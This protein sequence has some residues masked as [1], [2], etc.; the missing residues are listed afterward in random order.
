MLTM[1][2]MDL[3]QLL[4][5]EEERRGRAVEYGI[6]ALWILMFVF[7]GWSL[8]IYY[9]AR[10]YMEL[11]YLRTMLSV[12]N[13]ILI[14]NIVS[15]ILWF[16]VT[17]YILYSALFIERREKYN[18]VSGVLFFISGLAELLVA[19]A[20]WGYY[21]KIDYLNKHLAML[22]FEDVRA[23]LLDI[24]SGMSLYITASN[25]IVLMSIGLAFILIGISMK[26]YAD[27][28][29]RALFTIR[30]GEEYTAPPESEAEL[31]PTSYKEV[32]EMETYGLNI[33]RQIESGARALRSGGNMYIASGVL[34]LV[35][36]LMPGLST[37]AFILFI[38]GAI[39]AGQGRKMIEN[40]RRQL[41]QMKEPGEYK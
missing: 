3:D 4:V 38:L 25:I 19:L 23:R 10:E 14:L 20:I 6:F 30:I 15:N 32:L 36:I 24:S 7:Q 34:D 21:Q 5:P 8:Q 27:K 33:R 17:S 22:S 18:I 39:K 2:F 11:Q 37:F 35:S 13:Q 26:R 28:L 12:Q 9:S 29:I 1:D 31:S 41:L 40:V 16:I